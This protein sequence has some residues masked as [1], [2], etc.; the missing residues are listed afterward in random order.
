VISQKNRNFQPPFVEKSLLERITSA[1]HFFLE[2]CRIISFWRRLEIILRNVIRYIF[3]GYGTICVVLTAYFPI[4][5]IE[6]DFDFKRIV[7]CLL[8]ITTLSRVSSSHPSRPTPDLTFSF[9]MSPLTAASRLSTLDL[10]SEIFSS[11]EVEEMRTFL[12]SL[13]NTE[14]V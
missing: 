3:D 5:K 7:T 11:L 6:F 2:F 9:L 8:S 10:N 13:L 12:K 1:Y 4:R 14:V